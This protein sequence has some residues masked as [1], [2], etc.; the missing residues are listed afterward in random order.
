MLR[1]AGFRTCAVGAAWLAVAASAHAQGQA[2]SISGNS[3]VAIGLVVALV[4]LIFF[5]IS[6]ALSI[7][8]R[9]KPDD[10]AGVGVLEGIDEDDERPPR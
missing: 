8:R 2:P 7:T 1:T 10:D 9:D 5:F 3:W 6:G 4:L